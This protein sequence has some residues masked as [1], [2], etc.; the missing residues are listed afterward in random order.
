MKNKNLK[1]NIN[2][3]SVWF[4]ISGTMLVNLVFYTKAADPFNTIK[5]L[6][7]LVIAGY[8]LGHLLTTY[9]INSQTKSTYTKIIILTL[10]FLGSMLILALFSD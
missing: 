9:K 7:L 10:F 8:L 6:V 4:L 1:P 2:P 5:L 3:G